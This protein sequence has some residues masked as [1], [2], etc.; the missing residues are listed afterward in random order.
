MS[1]RNLTRVN[2]QGSEKFIIETAPA[3][4]GEITLV[5]TEIGLKLP[6]EVPAS[7]PLTPESLTDDQR[8]LVRALTKVDSFN[9]SLRTLSILQAWVFADIFTKIEKAGR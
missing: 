5:L 8:E 9:W 7:E 1:S 4:R 3:S 6:L 2:S